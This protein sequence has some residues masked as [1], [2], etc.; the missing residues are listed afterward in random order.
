MC[1]D[2]SKIKEKEM[3]LRE[4]IISVD[5]L[6]K[7]MFVEA[8]AGAGKT[9]LIVERVVQQLRSGYSGYYVY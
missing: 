1:V 7:N 6:D 5:N 2:N 4:Q 8:G 3:N 9:H